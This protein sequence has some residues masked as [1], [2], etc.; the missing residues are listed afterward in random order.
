MTS[1]LPHNFIVLFDSRPLQRFL[2]F[3]H[4]SVHL[5]ASN[6]T[7]SKLVHNISSTDHVGINLALSEPI[8]CQHMTISGLVTRRQRY[9]IF[10][11]RA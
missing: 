11:P 10:G 5:T 1:I 8:V 9:S 6:E 4:S 2:P 3:C 7:F